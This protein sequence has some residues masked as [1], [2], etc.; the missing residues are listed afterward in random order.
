[1]TRKEIERIAKVIK[2]LNWDGA[3]KAELW[4]MIGNAIIVS[5][6]NVAEAWAKWAK[7]CG[8]HQ[9]GDEGEE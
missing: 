6:T 9:T 1:M 8:Y 3:T 7:A 4:D 5:K 2:S